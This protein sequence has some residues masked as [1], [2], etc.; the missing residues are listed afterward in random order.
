MAE[1]L[2]TP[3]NV[4]SSTPAAPT[5]EERVAKIREF[6]DAPAFLE[7]EAVGPSV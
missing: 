6:V 1:L 7:V 3:S 5:F 2:L 4:M